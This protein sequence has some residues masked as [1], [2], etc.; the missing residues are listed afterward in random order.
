MLS[1]IKDPETRDRLYMVL[2]DGKVSESVPVGGC[3]AETINVAVIL[4]NR[5]GIPSSVS[6]DGGH[7]LDGKGKNAEKLFVISN[8][9]VW[10]ASHMAEKLDENLSKI[11]KVSPQLQW[12]NAQK[13]IQALSE[14]EEKEFMDLQ[15]KYLD[16]LKE[17]DEILKETDD[18]DRFVIEVS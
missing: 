11:D 8:R 16:L 6:E 5:L 10:V 14:E 15:R 12:K 13:Q 2:E 1:T 9:K 18:E 4:F 3:D 17:Q 7:V